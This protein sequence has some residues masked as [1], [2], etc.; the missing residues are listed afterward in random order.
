MRNN[1]LSSKWDITVVWRLY[2]LSRTSL[3]SARNG[4]LSWRTDWCSIETSSKLRN[5][6]VYR[7]MKMKPQIAPSCTQI[8]QNKHMGINKW[9]R[10]WTGNTF[11]NELIHK[12]GCL[13]QPSNN[14]RP[15]WSFAPPHGCWYQLMTIWL[16]VATN[17][18]FTTTMWLSQRPCGCSQ[19]P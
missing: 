12:S 10:K 8:N 17:W 9:I 1:T 13:H 19:R 15:L 2:M 14:R 5:C 6:E 3:Q 11:W 16:L 18:S 4:W 7:L